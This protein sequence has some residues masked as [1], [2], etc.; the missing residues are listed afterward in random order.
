MDEKT[1]L[2]VGAVL[3]GVWYFMRKPATVGTTPAAGGGAPGGSTT[4]TTGGGAAT[5]ALPTAGMTPA[6]REAYFDELG[7]RQQTDMENRWPYSLPDR[8]GVRY[9]TGVQV[10]A[11]GDN[12]PVSAIKDPLAGVSVPM[13]WY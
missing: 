7:R 1:I 12:A 5:G 10:L 11:P 4:P 9:Q 8:Q 6:Q 2:I 13:K 3:A